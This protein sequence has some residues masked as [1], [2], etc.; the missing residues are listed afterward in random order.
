MNIIAIILL[1]W[2]CG[3][4]CAEVVTYWRW[5]NKIRYAKVL[6]AACEIGLAIYLGVNL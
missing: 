1:S 3:M 4:D 2:C 5:L 6:T